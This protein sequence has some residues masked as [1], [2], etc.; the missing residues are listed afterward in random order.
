MVEA[1]I[2]TVSF[3]HSFLHSF[4]YPGY[5]EWYHLLLIMENGTAVGSRSSLRS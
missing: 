1:D 5:I 3:D 2:A 4:I